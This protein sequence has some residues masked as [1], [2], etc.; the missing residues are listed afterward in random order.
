MK[1]A[2]LLAAGAILVVA[3]A[4]A[5][6]IHQ[7]RNAEPPPARLDLQ[8]AEFTFLDGDETTFASM[9]PAP[10]LVN[11][12]AT[13]C[14]PCLHEMPLLDEAAQRHMKVRFA[15]VAIDHP[16]LA[17]KFLEKNPVNYDILSPK[18]DIFLLFE[19]AGNESGVLPYTLLLGEDGAIIAE[20]TGEFH[21]GEEIDSFISENLR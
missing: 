6:W 12:W 20:K 5:S 13:W 15:G 2:A 1:K 17:R 4:A 19:E 9:P 11:F 7:M 21:S 18:F 3:G 10:R 14:P 16:D 8:T